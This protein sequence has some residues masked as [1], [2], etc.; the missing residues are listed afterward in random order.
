MNKGRLDQEI[1]VDGRLVGYVCCDLRACCADNLRV[2]KGV[3]VMG[4]RSG[5]RLNPN[6]GEDVTKGLKP[7]SMFINL[8]MKRPSIA[9]H[10]MMTRGI[11]QTQLGLSILRGAFRASSSF[12]RMRTNISSGLDASIA[13]SRIIVENNTLRRASGGF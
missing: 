8:G 1:I 6:E 2:P 12:R 5:P 11:F 13:P 3:G 4:R 10:D 7:Y 9:D